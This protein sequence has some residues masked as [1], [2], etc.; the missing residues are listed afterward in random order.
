M[1]DNLI[2]TDDVIRFGNIIADGS[3]KA[4]NDRNVKDFA[5]ETGNA[6]QKIFDDEGIVDELPV[7]IMIELILAHGK[8]VSTVQST[9]RGFRE[10]SALTDE[11]I[12]GI[13]KEAA[14]LA[15]SEA[16]SET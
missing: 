6:I 8:L 12:D 11:E 4:P 7:P 3:E 10:F 13:R 9:L 16:I 2:N 5:I 14:A 1:T 15:I